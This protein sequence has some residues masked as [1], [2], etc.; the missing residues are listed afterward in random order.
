M[1]NEERAERLRGALATAERTGVG[2]PYPEALRA[3]AVEYRREREREGAALCEVAR[4]LGV[5]AVSLE[6]W[7]RRSPER[8]T[9]FR[10]IELVGEPMR[11]ASPAVVHGPRGLR[12]EGLTVSEIAEL[13]ERLS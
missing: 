8:E 1:K 7:S 13:I 4:E 12:I 3:T 10:A 6:R 9:S 2:R 5:S 11:R